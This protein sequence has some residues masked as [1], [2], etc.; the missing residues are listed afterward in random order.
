LWATQF[1]WVEMICMNG[2]L[3]HFQCIICLAIWSPNIEIATNIY[4]LAKHQKKRTTFK[5]MSQ[6]KMKKGKSYVHKQC[7]DLKNVPI[8]AST[9]NSTTF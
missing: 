7:W 8:F 3:D 2:G 9:K 4:N 1:P 5:D 6:I